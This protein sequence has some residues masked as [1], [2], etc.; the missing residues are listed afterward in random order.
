MAFSKFAHALKTKFGSRSKEGEDW[1]GNSR[2]SHPELVYHTNKTMTNLVDVNAPSSTG[3]KGS[4]TKSK[5]NI[6]NSLTL[7]N[8]SS[9]P[10]L[11]TKSMISIKP[12]NAQYRGYHPL[13]DTSVGETRAYP[14]DV[15]SP[16][17]RLYST[18]TPRPR[19]R[20][21]TDDTAPPVPPLPA[22][23][24]YMHVS[25]VLWSCTLL[26]RLS[27]GLL[28]RCLSTLGH[29]FQSILLILIAT[30]LIYTSNLYF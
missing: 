25:V 19:R 18:A 8:P 6:R 9:P 28:K 13:L 4:S 7:D 27:A 23:Y 1:R 21:Y 2:I 26:I 15:R 14:G 12:A 16:R 20:A 3:R 24:R 30:T 17:K 29:S 11:R 22:D 10:R 5:K